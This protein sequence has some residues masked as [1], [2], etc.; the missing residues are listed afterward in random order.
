MK[1]FNGNDIDWKAYTQGQIANRYYQIDK[2]QT[3]NPY[4]KTTDQWYSWNRGWNS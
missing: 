2:L 4:P 3:K 1:L